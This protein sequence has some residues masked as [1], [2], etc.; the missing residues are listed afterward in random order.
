MKRRI[1]SVIFLVALA[2]FTTILV[3]C[4]SSSSKKELADYVDPL[5]GTSN[6]R[7][8]LFPGP[9]LPFGMVKLSPDNTN[10]GQY[11]L[12]AG[13][14]YKINSI[15]GFSHVHSWM[16]SSVST[17]PTTGDL[18]I[19]VGTAEDPDAGY[20]S[21][22]NNKNTKASAGYYSTILDDYNIKVELTATTRGGFQRYTFPKT[23]EA[24][25]LFDLKFTE[26]EPSTIVGASI[27]KV[28]DTEIEGYV[29]REAGEWN[30][31]V[32]HFIARF[33]RPYTSMGGWKGSSILNNTDLIEITEDIDIGAFLNFDVQEDQEVLLQTAIS[34]VSVEQA[35]LNLTTEMDGFNWRFDAAHNNAREIWNN[36]LGKIKVEEGKETDKIKFYTGLYR[37]YSSK[38]IYSDVNG[39][40]VDACENVQQVNPDEFEVYGADAFWGSFWNLNQIWSLVSPDKS[41]KWVKSLLELYDKNGWLHDAPGGLE[42][43]SIMVAAHQI[44]FIVNIWQKGIRG[45]DGEKALKAMKELQMNPGQAHECGG[46]AGNRNI[47]TYIKNGFVPANEGPVSNT[48][49]YAYDDWCVAQMAKSL[50][51]TDDYE[52]FMQRSQNYRNVF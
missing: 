24:R 39:K 42:Y 7:W 34:Y 17:M 28:S 41:E 20:R 33:N 46:Y 25:I 22:I 16:M 38:T 23:D 21:R 37:S 52:Y 43:S 8:M 30:E 40:Y 49:E 13:Y 14:E 51:K 12:G 44:P 35:R 18:K 26:E 48:L 36:L 11:A 2:F 27:K 29:I 31:Y 15:S 4:N 47:E 32:V 9:C 50:G 3:N 10:E 45:Y 6:S 19:N 1:K 5:L